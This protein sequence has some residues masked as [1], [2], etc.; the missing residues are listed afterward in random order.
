MTL[1]PFESLDMQ[2]EEFRE[3]EFIHMNEESGCDERNECP[4]ESDRVQ[5]T[6]HWRNS[7]KYFTTLKAQD[8]ML[9]ANISL[10]EKNM[11]V[12]KGI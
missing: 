3:D 5:K 11:T 12:H 9:E 4:R 8:E 2:P 1:L 6:S 7:Q 10:E